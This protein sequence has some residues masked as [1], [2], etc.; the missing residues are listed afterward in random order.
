MQLDLSRSP[1]SAY[2]SLLCFS[3]LP[4]DWKRPGV[5]L[6]NVRGVFGMRE[7]FAI[8]LLVGGEEW[9]AEVDATPSC[10]T[11]RAAGATAEFVFS[12]P[13]TLRIRV[14]GGALALYSDP[15]TRANLLPTSD[16]SWRLRMER[17]SGH[18]LLTSLHGSVEAER[19]PPPADGPAPK[20]NKPAP[21]SLR[22][23]LQPDAE[24]RLEMALEEFVVQERLV[25]LGGTFD[26]CRA[27]AEAWWSDWLERIPE[28]P[29]DFRPAARLARYVNGS[30]VVNVTGALRRPTMLMSKNWMNQC[31]TWDHCFNAI[32]H[33]ASEPDLAWDQW[34]VPFDFMQPSGALPDSVTTAQPTWLAAKPPI[35]GWALGWMERL[36]GPLSQDRVETAYDYLSRWTHWWLECRDADGDGLPEYHDGCDSGWDNATVFLRDQAVASPDLPSYLVLQMDTLADLATRLGRH[37]AAAQWRAASAAMLERLLGRLWEGDRFVSREAFTGEACDDGDSLIN[38]LPIILGD[39]LPAAHREALAEGLRVGGRFV[40]EF[41]PATESVRSPFFHQDGYW[42][43]AI[44][45]PVTMMLVDGLDRAGFPEQAREMARNYCAMCQDEGMSENYSPLTGVAQSDRAYTWG[46]SVFLVLAG[47]YLRAE[48]AGSS[49]VESTESLALATN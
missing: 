33:A 31:W 14:S 30:A 27:S 19:L 21:A 23:V 49:A 25:G 37:A 26:E 42:Q 10:L 4:P 15:S 18:Y 35:H 11:L 28:V 41:G 48:S 22:L 44:W 43:G 5:V 38:F 24:G 47:E 16:H 32:A 46:S 9:E 2:G 40:T 36:G 12:A 17:T 1:F 13:E 7:L 20:K 3:V 34:L 39:R 45:P 8:K 29:A 6:R